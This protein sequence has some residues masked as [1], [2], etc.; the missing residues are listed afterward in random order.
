MA[1]N[2]AALNIV[3]QTW[4]DIIHIMTHLK[5]NIK[6]NACLIASII[7]LAAIF[8]TSCSNRE[9]VTSKMFVGKWKSSRIETPLHLHENN[10]WE[11]KKDDGTV[12]QYGVWEYKNKKIIWSY[13]IGYQTGHDINQVL[14]ATP[15]RFQ[16]LES[17]QSVTTFDRLKQAS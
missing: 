7:M 16:L 8:L 12:L 1:A 5:I 10:E 3:Q 11:I 6:H 13:K 14:T 2:P 9:A 15:D 4:Q 17:D